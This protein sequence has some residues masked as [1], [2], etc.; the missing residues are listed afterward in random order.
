M[1][2]LILWIVLL[3]LIW[4]SGRNLVRAMLEDPGRPYEP[5]R[6]QIRRPWEEIEDARWVD[7]E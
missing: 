6:R 3:Y 1:L 5:E 4:R 7:L 2:K